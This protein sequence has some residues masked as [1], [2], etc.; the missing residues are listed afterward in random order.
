MILCVVAII[1]CQPVVVPVSPTNAQATTVAAT[2]RACDFVPGKSVPAYIPPSNSSPLPTPVPIPMT[3]TNIKI[4]SVTL[5]RQMNLYYQIDG[6]IINHY[7]YADYNGKDWKAISLK[8]KE[9]IQN[10][11]SQTDFYL[12][13]QQMVSELGDSR[14]YFLSPSGQARQRALAADNELVGIGVLTSPISDQGQIINALNWVFPGSPADKAGLKPHDV[15]LKVNGEPFI[16]ANDNTLTLGP[17]GS[18]VTVT[19]RSGDMAQKDVKMNISKVN[20]TSLVDYCLVPGTRIG[21]MRWEE[22]KYPSIVDQTVDALNQM[23]GLNPLQG[24]IL[25]Q[26]M[27]NNSNY[28]VLQ[29]LLGLFTGGVQGSFVSNRVDQNLTPVPFTANPVTDVSGSLN[30]PLVVIQ[31]ETTG[32]AALFEGLL[33]LAGRA[34]IVGQT[35]KGDAYLQYVDDFPDGSTLVLPS[36]TFQPNGKIPGYWDKTGVIPDVSVSGR[37]DQY[38]ESNDPYLAKALELLMKK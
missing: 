22:L 37:W 20:Q 6:D 36:M 33:Q 32:D 19:I 34:K 28:T 25:D 9:L 5:A 14:A 4:E 18:S 35:S 12:A 21:Y 27:I 30:V 13:L 8:Y 7:V 26:R 29:L 24:L 17:A 2:V 15:I 11:L 23:S 3:F 10:G 38:S 31:D 16:G 1:A